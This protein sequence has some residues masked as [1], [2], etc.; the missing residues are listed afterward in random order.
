[1]IKI[2]VWIFQK[3]EQHPIKCTETIKVP[4]HVLVFIISQQRHI[5]CLPDTEMHMYCQYSIDTNAHLLSIQ[6]WQL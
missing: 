5:N 1:M 3:S 6:Y 2:I 4:A